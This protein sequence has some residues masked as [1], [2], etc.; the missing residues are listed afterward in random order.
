MAGSGLGG[1]WPGHFWPSHAA[2]A[3]DARLRRLSQAAG[4]SSKLAWLVLAGV[5]VAVASTAV[6]ADWPELRLRDP[7]RQ[8]MLRPKLA[9]IPEGHPRLFIRGEEDLEKVRER[10]KSSPE[11]AGRMLEGWVQGE[12]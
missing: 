6:F 5:L 8:K 9:L 4:P 10:I 3:A 2:G 7:E 11:V 1:W 12:E